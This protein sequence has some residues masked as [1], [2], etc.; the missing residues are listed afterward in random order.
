MAN[1]PV[2]GAARRWLGAVVVTV[3][4]VATAVVAP[5]P[6]TAGASVVLTSFRGHGSIDEAYVVGAPPRTHLTL[7]D[8]AGA[9]V[10]SG[11]VDRLGSLI[12]RNLAPGSGYRFDEG[13]GASRRA[14]PGFSVLSTTGSTPPASF[15]SS[16]RLHVGLNYVRMRDGI[17]IAATVRLPPGK[18]LADGPFPTVIEYSGYGTAAPHSLIDAEEGK[19]PSNDPLLPD[20]STVVGALV[21][22]LLGFA[23]VSVQMRGT[24]CSG[25]AF[26][27]LGYPSDYD[28][29]DVVQAVGAQP[30]VLHHKVG[31]VGISYSGLS[32]FP[33]AGTDPPDLAAIAPLSPTDDL[34]STGYPGGIYNDGF[35]KSWI[36]QRISDAEPAPQGGQPWARAEI[37]AGDKTCLANQR[38]HLQAESLETLVG[39]GLARTP[40]LFDRRSPVVWATHVKVPVFLVG[41]LQDEEV[42]P[43]WPA[44]ITALK[45]DRD[46]YV[47]MDNGTHT[48]SLGPDT[49]SRWLEFLDIYVAG[50][51]PKA[52]PTLGLLAP[53][54]YSSLTGGAP[55]MPVPAVR[56]T[57]E[58]SVSAAEKAFAASDPRVRVLF[59]NGGGSLGPGALQPAFSAGFSTWPPA[60]TVTSF[61]LGPDGSLSTAPPRSASSASFRPDP[62]VRPADDL[63]SS[64]NAWAAQPPYHWT[65]VPAANGIAFQTPAFIR[66]TTIVGPASLD[67]MLKSTAPVTDLQVTVTEVR[68]GG[69]EEE[70]VTSGFLRSS[71]RTLTAASTALDPV[72]TYL[73]S[74][75]RNLPA[76]RFTLVRIPVDPIAHAFR[77]GTSL[78]IVISAPGGDRPSWTFE[79]PATHGAVVDTVALGATAGSTLVVDEVG[80]VVPT[81]TLPACGA[82][83]GEPCRAYVP[84]G[85]QTPTAPPAG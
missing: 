24:G 52:A 78:R 42:G 5:P 77:A 59:D 22:P 28:G 51:V 54:L 33:V 72:P 19:A 26:D 80:G 64:A 41:S 83:R 30:W 40:S 69:T 62:A 56:F 65:P 79:T 4:A 14:T 8:G 67:L 53:A 37:A 10:G 81:A 36:A 82:L 44:L 74:D 35:A 58:P 46:V 70:Y 57:T 73:G 27:L 47:T 11:V 1:F 31:L 68:P 21:A 6:G 55:A 50:E 84:A 76:G 29:Y 23:A 43:Q 15:Y 39:P 18:T 9:R 38:L 25:G 49:I 2:R 61:S 16:Q 71:N 45:G 13:T 17:L 48:D 63:S 60:G 7:V 75:K 12:V 34:F 32:Q 3:S 66:P 85:N 20:S